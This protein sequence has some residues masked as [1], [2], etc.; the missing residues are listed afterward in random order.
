MFCGFLDCK[1]LKKEW[2]ICVWKRCSNVIRLPTNALQNVRNVY[3][4]AHNVI[5]AGNILSD[6]D[7]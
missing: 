4:K 3:C 1:S 6:Q 2:R 5:K 7:H